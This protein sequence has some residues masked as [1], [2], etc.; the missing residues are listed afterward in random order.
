MLNTILLAKLPDLNAWVWADYR[1]AVLFAVIMPLILLL[2][3]FIRRIE[4]IQRLLITYW[5]VSSLLAITVYLMIAALPVGFMA[6]IAARILIPVGLWFW[7]DANEEIQEMPASPLKTCFTSWRWAITAWNLIG[8]VLFLPSI[9]CAF[10]ETPD[11]LQDQSCLGWL[12]PTWMYRE[13]FHPNLNPQ[14]LGLLGLAGLIFYVM[15]FSYFVVIKLKRY[16]RSATS[17]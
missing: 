8:A 12:E 16:G 17:Y 1:M 13:I 6:A 2:W 5:R 14:F 9:H 7:V 3:A 11:L 10:A 15:F 4:V